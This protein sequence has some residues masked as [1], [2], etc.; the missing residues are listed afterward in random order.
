MQKMIIEMMKKADERKLIY[1]FC[2][3]FD[4]RCRC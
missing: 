3:G 2:E 1:F 4:G